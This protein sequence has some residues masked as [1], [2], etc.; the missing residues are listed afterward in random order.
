MKFNVTNDNNNSFYLYIAF[1][2]HK[3]NEQ[4]NNEQK[5]QTSQVIILLSVAYAAVTW[6][7][8]QNSYEKR[9]YEARGDL[10]F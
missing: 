4:K 5:T 10:S 1:Q 3:A 6:K 9:P 7:T 8:K 2:W